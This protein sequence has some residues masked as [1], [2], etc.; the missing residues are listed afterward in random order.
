[1]PATAHHPHRW[2]VDIVNATDPALCGGKAAGLATLEQIGSG[3]PRAICLTTDLYRHWLE[4][5]G[6]G[7]RLTERIAAASDAGARRRIL[8]A[9]RREVGAT[10]LS[11]GVEA[12][13]RDALGHLAI[14]RDDLISVRSSGVEEDQRHASHAGIYASL[15]VPGHDTSAV[16]AGVRTCWASLWTEPAW[17]YRERLAI[18]HA[19]AAMAV[20]VQRFVPAVS[21]GVVFSADPLTS[22]RTTVVIEAGWGT[23]GALVAGRMTPDEYRISLNG[24]DRPG[25]RRRPGR[26]TTMTV[27][28]N[29][30]EA[31]LP[32]ADGQRA[33]PVL[34]DEKA[35]ELAA[36]AKA[37]EKRLG[38]PVDVE[39]VCDGARFWTVQAR[40]ITTLMP[41]SGARAR[42]P[43]L[44]TRANLKEVF[45]EL[46]SPLALSY[47]SRYL[48]GMFRTYCAAQGY[49]LP[50]DVRLVSVSRG[51]PY[52]NLSLMQHMTVARGGDP[53][54][55]G[56][57]YG[58][59]RPA[60]P[61][62]RAAAAPVH[63]RMADR[64]R[65]A[66]ELLA[67]FFKTP[68]RGRRLF[69]AMRREAAGL[70][71]IP[72][73]AL[74][75]RQLI[76]HFGRFSASMLRDSTLHRLHEVVSAQ[77]RAYMV[78]EALLRAWAPGDADTLLKQMMTGL[79]T[80]PN[81]Q[82]T[83]ALMNLAAQAARDD[84]AHAYFAEAGDDNALRRYETAL[85]G[86]DV[87]AGLAA[88]MREFGHRGPY[89]SDV[90]SPRFADDP[91]PLLRLIQLHV[92]AGGAPDA[93]GHAAERSR[94][95]HAAIAE[96]RRWL[97]RGR[98]RL[99]FATRW[100]VFR[101]VCDALQR[102]VA[103]RDEC[104]H[105]TTMMVAHLRRLVLEIGRR[106][107]REGTLADATDAF[108]LTWDEV[109]RVLLDTGGAWRALAAEQRCQR[110]RDAAMEAP[111]VVDD[112]GA[113]TDVD[114]VTDTAAGDE[115]LGYGVSSGVVTGRIRVVR[116]GA[117]IGHLSGEIVVLPAIE[118]TLTP[119]LPLVQG[120]I[121][122]MGGLLSHAAIIAREYGLPAVVNVRD[123][124]RRLRDGDRVELDGTTGRIRILERAG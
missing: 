34:S 63:L 88:F 99:G 8:E 62:S 123:A 89:E 53:A 109:P 35:R 29:G 112:D 26:Q 83:Y 100:T 15:V 16:I 20:V 96:V 23:G 6:L 71:A 97:R 72:L 5:S 10:P 14:G 69:R 9:M 79:G 47:L 54:D 50:S 58:T 31:T 120:F 36:V 98:G 91:A 111:D 84:R 33:R 11:E 73:D 32:L 110:A 68:S 17:T 40:P 108:F 21:S 44:W 105:V 28:R 101:I 51:R 37:V 102:L 42:R 80:L 103:L 116:S 81:M 74:T 86:T 76:A 13:L 41:R 93:A 107:T 124:T 3:V 66:R 121:A 38:R 45:P 70:A 77:S 87:L 59:A 46:P 95:R 27:W 22:D 12:A 78:L 119:I 49:P 24:H 55:V 43:T 82:M 30:Q 75:D 104:R 106:A 117:T 115:M 1:M 90:M 18:P 52:L 39:W 7:P 85:A 118:P 48:N 19:T 25:V 67:T 65:L 92:R 122:E 114:P 64:V 56:R 94:V 57:L 60:A 113:A 4:V 61:R 2:L